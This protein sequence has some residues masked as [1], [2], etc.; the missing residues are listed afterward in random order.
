[1]IEPVELLELLI[2]LIAI[3]YMIFQVWANWQ[4][5][6]PSERKK[7]IEACIYSAVLEVERLFG[8]KTG[9]AKRV[10]VIRLFYTTLPIQITRWVNAEQLDALIVAAVEKMKQYFKDNP[11]AAANILG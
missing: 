7:Q 11:E 8:G 10:A 2:A 6:T 3:M 9:E 5:L 4:S 1:M